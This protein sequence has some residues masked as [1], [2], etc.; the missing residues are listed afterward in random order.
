MQIDLKEGLDIHIEG[1]IAKNNSLP[2][3]YFVKISTSLQNLILELAN[4]TLAGETVDPENF[5]IEISGFFKG[6][7][8]PR[9]E[10]SPKIQHV[11]IGDVS[12]QRDL[13][14][15]RLNDLLAISNEGKYTKIKDLYPNAN[16]RNAVVESVYSFIGSFG[17]APVAFGKYNPQ[18]KTF[19]T[20]YKIKKFTSELRNSLLTDILEEKATDDSEYMETAAK[21]KFK[22]DSKGKLSKPK[23]QKSFTTPNLKTAWIISEI[24]INNKEYHISN[25]LAEFEKEDDFYILKSDLLGIM[26]TG[27]SEEDAKQS[28]YEEFD[29]ICSTYLALSDKKLSPKLLEVKKLLKLLVTVK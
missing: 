9:Y 29:Y 5:K 10:F 1:E 14:N 26:G 4:N 20:S 6:S 22:I 15:S 25:L 23:I 12:K 3:D 18:S 11:T 8:I 21:V 17:T 19:K 13:V 7:A 24:K 27:E 2:I 16:S 28:F